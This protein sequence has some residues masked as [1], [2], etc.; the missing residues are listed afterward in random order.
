MMAEAAAQSPGRHFVERAPAD[1]KHERGD[2]LYKLVLAASGR[3]L[4]DLSPYFH[5]SPA[6]LH[7]NPRWWQT[8]IGAASA[9]HESWCLSP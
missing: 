3:E 9:Q 6:V 1:K 4:E 8:S 2:D 7:G 5:V